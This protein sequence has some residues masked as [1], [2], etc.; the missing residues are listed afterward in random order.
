M[1]LNEA[2]L[3]AIVESLES[4][5]KGCDGTCEH[6]LIGK[7]LLQLRCLHPVYANLLAAL[8][9]E[10]PIAITDAFALGFCLAHDYYESEKLE[11]MCSQ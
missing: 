10:G 6:C 11:E 4:C 1:P 3:T 9:T 8:L 7:Q 2:K 5:K